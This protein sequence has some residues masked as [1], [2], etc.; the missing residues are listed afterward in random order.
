MEELWVKAKTSIQ[1]RLTSDT[2]NLWIK[3]LQWKEVKE[4]EIVLECPNA[5]FKEWVNRY[6]LKTVKTPS[7]ESIGRSPLGLLRRGAGSP[8]LTMEM[9][10]WRSPT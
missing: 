9:G 10:R 5:F 7:R 2:F 3:P 8:P 6:Y 4:G 1:E